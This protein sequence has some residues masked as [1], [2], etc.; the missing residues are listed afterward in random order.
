MK[1]EKIIGAMSKSTGKISSFDLRDWNLEE[2]EEGASAGKT[3]RSSHETSVVLRGCS[4]LHCCRI[5]DVECATFATI[6]RLAAVAMD[7][8][9]RRIVGFLMLCWRRKG[10]EG[11]CTTTWLPFNFPR[12]HARC[13]HRAAAEADLP[14]SPCFC[15]SA[16]SST[17]GQQ[18]RGQ[19]MPV[20]FVLWDS[21]S[22]DE[23][24]PKWSRA[25]QHQPP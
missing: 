13:R 7:W 18:E 15:L 1:M 12:T 10:R 19:I 4:P 21:T 2:E 23:N 25:L 24:V 5:G 3:Y 11:S 14:T 16:R 6:A 22:R 17:P 20:P 9:G 8:G